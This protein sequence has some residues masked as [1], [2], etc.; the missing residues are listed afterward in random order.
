MLKHRT[1]NLFMPPPETTISGV[2]L[3]Y[4]DDGSFILNGTCT[5][6]RYIYAT[7]PL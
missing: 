7:A 4:A 2:T 6:D 3:S 1:K 5:Q